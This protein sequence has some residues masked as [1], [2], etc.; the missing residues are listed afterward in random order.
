MS[1][2]GADCVKEKIQ[3]ETCPNFSCRYFNSPF[4]ICQ[5]ANFS[6]GPSPLSLFPSPYIFPTSLL[7]LS[8]S[9]LLFLQVHAHILWLSCSLI[10]LNPRAQMGRDVGSMQEERGVHFLKILPT[11]SPSNVTNALRAFISNNSLK[12]N[13]DTTMVMNLEFSTLDTKSSSPVY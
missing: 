11:S 12:R 9:M 13:Q 5:S 10:S 2:G 6:I 7:Y 8:S 4:H 1:K 3:G